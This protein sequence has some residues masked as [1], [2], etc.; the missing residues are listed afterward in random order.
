MT[1]QLFR[2]CKSRRLWFVLVAVFANGAL[3][4]WFLLPTAKTSPPVE[5][6]REQPAKELNREPILFKKQIQAALAK[7]TVEQSIEHLPDFDDTVPNMVSLG[8]TMFPEYGYDYAIYYFSGLNRVRKIL[9]EGSD[10]LGRVTPIL[11]GKLAHA[12]D[13]YK[14]ITKEYWKRVNSGPLV[15]SDWDEFQ[16]R[17]INTSCAV[18]LLAQ[19]GANDALPLMAKLFIDQGD[20]AKLFAKGDLPFDNFHPDM[21]TVVNRLFLFCAMHHLMHNHPRDKLSPQAL[22]RLDEYLEAS[23]EIPAFDEVS[24]PSWRATYEAWDYRITILGN[25]LGMD[26]Q[27]HIRVHR[28]PANMRFQEGYLSGIPSPKVKKWFAKMKLFLDEAYPAVTKPVPKPKGA[29]S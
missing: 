8:N 4:L 25:D 3:A 15:S 14:R 11:K 29:S 7:E 13:D 12:M 21:N 5:K 6:Q 16:K 27:P 17:R 23:K 28:F 20:T 9:E 22:K 1:G 24:V 2:C 18:Y 10:N 19:F 26:K